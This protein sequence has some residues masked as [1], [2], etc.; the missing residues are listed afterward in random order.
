MWVVSSFI[1]M[2]DCCL[3]PLH[4]LRW[5]EFDHHNL[6]AVVRGVWF[7]LAEAGGTCE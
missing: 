7:V 2:H 1:D 6:N 4:F 5:H 3:L